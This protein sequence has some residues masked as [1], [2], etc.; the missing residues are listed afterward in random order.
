[1]N[2]DTETSFGYRTTQHDTFQT[3]KMDLELENSGC[4]G[5]S[6]IAFNDQCTYQSLHAIRLSIYA[7]LRGMQKAVQ[8]E[9]PTSNERGIVHVDGMLF[10]RG[11]VDERAPRCSPH[12]IGREFNQAEL[13]QSRTFII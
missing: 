12:A 2:R 4:I 8:R 10:L 1:M 3:P 13:V 5:L 6:G 7:Y 11:S 9:H